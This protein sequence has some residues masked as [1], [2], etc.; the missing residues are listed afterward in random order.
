MRKHRKPRKSFDPFQ[1]ELD[2]EGRLVSTHLRRNRRTSPALPDGRENGRRFRLGSFFRNIII[3]GGRTMKTML[4]LSLLLTA[5]SAMA[6][7]RGTTY[8]QD[9][10]TTTRDAQGR[11]ISKQ[12]YH[13]NA[14][15]T[16]T[17]TTRNT[18]GQ[19]IQTERGDPPTR[20]PRKT[21]QR[22]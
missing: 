6:G 13:T 1:Q 17:K 2:F 5:F 19:T 20:Y 9:R 16:V 3:K 15:G 22:R 21:T 10:T 12:T 7:S 8:R 14:D 4:A 18:R 11:T